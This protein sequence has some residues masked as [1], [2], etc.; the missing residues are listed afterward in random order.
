MSFVVVDFETANNCRSSACSIGYAIVENSEIV[1]TGCEFIKPEPF[2][3]DDFNTMI[4][5]ITEEMVEDAENIVNVWNSLKNKF[6][7][8]IIVAH[9]ASFDMSVLRKGFEEF[10][11]PYPELKYACSLKIAQKTIPNLINYKLPTLADEFNIDLNH[12]DAES[13][14]QAAA[15]ILINI[16][17]KNEVNSLEDLLNKLNLHTGKIESDSYT[18]FSIADKKSKS[19]SY[20]ALEAQGEINEDSDFFGKKVVFT[21]TLESMTRSVAAQFVVN[22]GGKVMTSVSKTTDFLVIGVQD[23]RQLAKGAT[24]SSKMKKAYDLNAAGT[25]IQIITEDDFLRMI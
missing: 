5:G 1:E 8:N 9:N 20:K 14:A 4:H 3:F 7:D 21:G 16:I 6:Q 22:C 17:K 13:D 24:M 12:H 25:G 23:Y 11:E 19:K 15:L 2:Y 10:E 18:P